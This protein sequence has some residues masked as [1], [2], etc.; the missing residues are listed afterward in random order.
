[1]SVFEEII[2]DVPALATDASTLLGPE[3][4][5]EEVHVQHVSTPWV[6]LLLQ[7]KE[8]ED[9]VKLLCHACIDNGYRD[10]LLELHGE[11]A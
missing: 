5:D 6:R 2:N 1:M 4:L 9:F 11:E 10:T 3:R 8:P 7:H